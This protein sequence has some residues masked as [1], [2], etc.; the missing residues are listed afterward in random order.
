MY[1]SYDGLSCNTFY[2]MYFLYPS[3]QISFIL[4][5][6]HTEA[7]HLVPDSGIISNFGCIILGCLCGEVV[8]GS[9]DEIIGS[10]DDDDDGV[11][12]DEA[13]DEPKHGSG[14][15]P[16]ES[17][18]LDGNSI[19]IFENLPKNCTKILQK[20]SQKVTQ[21]PNSLLNSVPG[22]APLPLDHVQPGE[23][24]GRRD[25]GVDAARYGRR[26]SRLVERR[27]RRRRRRR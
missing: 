11:E 25:G 17:R 18:I 14:S 4:G 20:C 6:N 7:S 16:G 26:Q 5:S 21:S 9:K 10:E 24:G 12:D 2:Q 23:P 13:V 27:H 3:Y 22:S 1:E 19:D 15:S 8:V